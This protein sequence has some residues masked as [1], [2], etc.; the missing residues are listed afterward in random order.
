MTAD[1]LTKAYAS[2]K[3]VTLASITEELLE[4]R[5]LARTLNDPDAMNSATEGLMKLHG[6]GVE[7]H[8]NEVNFSEEMMLLICSKYLSSNCIEL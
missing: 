8:Q 4:A 2:S 1:H 6:L 3:P 5:E 7:K